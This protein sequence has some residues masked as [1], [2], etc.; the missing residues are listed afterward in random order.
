MTIPAGVGAPEP[1][2]IIIHSP[3]TGDPERVREFAPAAAPASETKT[4]AP[5]PSVTWRP[6]PAVSVAPME[7]VGGLDAFRGLLIV[8]MNFA[9]TIPAWGPFPA[10]MY[11]QQVPPS[12]TA[13][14]APLSGLT[15]RDLLFPM[16][17]FTMAT[18]LPVVMGAR[19]ARG[20]PY[21]EIAWIATRRA[22]LLTVFAL[23]IGH[24][25]PYW[26]RD[27]TKTGNVIA[28]VG[29]AVAF[30]TFVQWPTRW[31]ESTRLWLRRLAWAAVAATLFVLPMVYGA[32]FD[33]A[34]R[35]SVIAAVAFCTLAGALLWLGTRTRPRLRIAL[36]AVVVI[37]RTLASRVDW[38]GGVW[39]ARPFS[40][41]YES[42]YLD[43]LIIV[44]AGTIAGDLLYR[45]AR[46][47]REPAAERGWGGA[48]R[49]GIAA[50][51]LAMLPVLCVGLFQRRYPLAT[52]IAVSALSALLVAL[53]LRPRGERERAL[54]TLARWGA[55]LLVIGMLLEPLDGGIKK[56]PQTLAYL[57]VTSGAAM[58]ALASILLLF[59]TR[60]ARWL[61]PLIPV[62]QNALFGYVVIMLG[63]GHLLWL[64]G[65]GEAF[66]ATWP[67][68]TVRSVVL[69]LGAAL[70]VGLAT[71][72][73]LVW[74]T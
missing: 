50:L 17:V 51:G 45:L 40:W 25:N 73:R 8:A 72:R 52:T 1:Q 13:A 65:A 63:L 10:W 23:I 16:F 18:A 31:R 66:T 49:G 70:L 21:P 46:A 37:G 44:I 27:Y 20:K 2:P 67:Q 5:S 48:R 60:I 6:A 39:Y 74:K 4:I 11:H 47:P 41:F 42:W 38:V 43:L 71:K 61:E 69:T 30:V 68:A 7:R 15:W 22:F 34:R 58:G 62:G 59:E 53:T 64:V 36:L 35:D 54:A 33:I 56:D 29:L 32:R 26:T 28:L 9:F 55:A 24:V 57:L 19:L 12:P 14:Y 3:I